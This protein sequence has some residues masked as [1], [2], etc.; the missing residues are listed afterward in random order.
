M[1]GNVILE[2]EER[3]IF[4]SF[5]II[6]QLIGPTL[7]KI[8]LP[9]KKLFL[10][11][12]LYK[13]DG[14]AESKSLA[15]IEESATII[16]KRFQ[17]EYFNKSLP[18]VFRAAAKNWDCVKKWNLDYFQIG[19]GNKDVL[20]I[21]ANGLTS[22]ENHSD[23][24]FLTIRDLINNIKEGGKKYLRF[25]PLLENNPNLVADLNMAWLRS[26]QGEKTFAS[27]YYMFMGGAGQKTL[28]HTDQPCN[29]YVQIYGEKKWTLYSSKDSALLY[30]EISNSAYVKSLVDLGSIDSEKYPLFKYAN[31]ME[32]VLRP[33][34]VLYVPPHVWHHVEN[35]SDTI[36]VG[37]RYSS[38]RAALSSSICFTML[39][40]MSTNPPIWKT[41]EYGKLDT[42]L[43]W[44]HAGGK[45]KEILSEF[46]SRMGEKN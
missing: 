1:K 15:T 28:L 10:N 16:P 41:M 36:A 39:R 30:P 37:F 22:R 18:V 5:L 11:Y 17:E 25:S 34:D 20:L 4:S 14:T 38:L 26:M 33:G 43:I 42:N 46:H 31:K 6:E 13:L 40:V 32:I 35:L 9:F 45:I 7:F 8:L 29:L 23:Y 44:G 24:E 3:F 2:K 27:T 21:N 12:L 19:Y